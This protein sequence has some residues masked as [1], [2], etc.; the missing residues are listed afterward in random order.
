MPAQIKS[1]A[2]NSAWVRRWKNAKLGFPSPR[3]ATITP[4]WLRVERAII[5]FMSHSNMAAMPAMVI[6][7]LPT[8][9]IKFL[10]H[11]TSERNG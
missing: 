7:I 10:N 2:L 4:S 9:K 11:Q 1:R 6:V 3:L 5:F 8:K